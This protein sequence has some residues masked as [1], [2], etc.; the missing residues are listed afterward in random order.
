M[1]H[2]PRPPSLLRLS[3]VDISFRASVAKRRRLPFPSSTKGY[4]I[5]PGGIGHQNCSFPPVPVVPTEFL[6]RVAKRSGHSSSTQS[7]PTGQ[8]FCH[9]PGRPLHQKIEVSGHKKTSWSIRGSYNHP[10]PCLASRSVFL[11]PGSETAAL[12]FRQGERQPLRTEDSDAVLK[13]TDFI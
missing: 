3:L 13:G 7:P 4:N 8:R 1:S 5:F 2:D 6:G 12:S 11:P 9:R 10:E